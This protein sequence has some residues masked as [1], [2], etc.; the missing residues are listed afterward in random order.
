M[1]FPHINIFFNSLLIF[2]Y[3]NQR[4]YKLFK[5]IY[6][7]IIDWLRSIGDW[8]K[9]LAITTQEFYHYSCSPRKKLEKIWTSL[10]ESHLLAVW[11]I[12]IWSGLSFLGC[13]SSVFFILSKQKVSS[14]YW[15]FLT[16]K[17]RKGVLASIIFETGCY[18]I[19]VFARFY[20]ILFL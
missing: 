11:S 3:E 17:C 2:F 14:C 9:G 1:T 20:K 10:P 16:L 8:T 13:Y 15:C 18:E 6:A 5:C 19:S 4:Y 12:Y 7:W